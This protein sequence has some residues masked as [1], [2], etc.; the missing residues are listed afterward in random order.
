MIYRI[1]ALKGEAFKRKSDCG[2]PFPRYSLYDKPLAP[3][4]EGLHALKVAI[5][6]LESAKSSFLIIH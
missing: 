6:A 2:G 3:G 5:S 4:E 1:P